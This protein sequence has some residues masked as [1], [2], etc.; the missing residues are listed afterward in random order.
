[1]ITSNNAHPFNITDQDRRIVPIEC[2]NKYAN[3][4]DSDPEREKK[5]QE[6]TEYFEALHNEIAK[7][8]FYK[9]LTAFF[10][11]RDISKFNPRRFPRT[12]MRTILTEA[13]KT[14]YELFVERN[15]RPFMTGRWMTKDD[16]EIPF[17]CELC[18]SILSKYA[19][20][21]GY[22]VCSSGKVLMKFRELGLEKKRVQKNGIRKGYY[23]FTEEGKKKWAAQIKEYEEVAA[24]PLDPEER[25][26]AAQDDGIDDLPE[27]DEKGEQIDDADF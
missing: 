24:T 16:K 4:S 9:Q 23:Q 21:N 27:P 17:T 12:E 2:S 25:R 3:P 26:A 19:E 15:I 5:D 18:Y 1:M 7:K 13:S 10:L 22:N 14:V 11:N 6:R 8:G 20:K